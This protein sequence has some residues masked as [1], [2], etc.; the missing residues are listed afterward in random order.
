MVDVGQP[1]PDVVGGCVL[2]GMWGAPRLDRVLQRFLAE[3]RGLRHIG[4][5][6]LIFARSPPNRAGVRAPP[7]VVA[8]ASAV[9][10]WPLCV[11]RV[12][13]R[14]AVAPSLADRHA[15]RSAESQP[16]PSAG[17]FVTE[18]RVGP[19][20]DTPTRHSDALVCE[21]ENL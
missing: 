13:L 5:N 9:G 21:V 3:S 14:R 1:D 10:S 6:L 4:P 19:L 16:P 20:Q 8:G 18:C 11:T 12:R 17:A 7:G 15:R 2:A